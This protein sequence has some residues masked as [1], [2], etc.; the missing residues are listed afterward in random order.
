M[1]ASIYCVNLPLLFYEM[2]YSTLLAST[3]K[4]LYNARKYKFEYTFEMNQWFYFELHLLHGQ[5]E[6]HVY[7]CDLIT[8]KEKVHM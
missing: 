5:K 4:H 7:V 6:V 3:W 8:L 2:T 1:K